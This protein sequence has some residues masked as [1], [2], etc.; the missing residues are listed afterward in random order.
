MIDFQNIATRAWHD[1]YVD[2][3]VPPHEIHVT[4][5]DTCARRTW[6]Q[7]HNVPVSDI[8]S[9]SSSV[10]PAVMGTAVHRVYVP[11]FA[12]RL[13]SHPDIAR[14]DAHADVTITVDGVTIHGEADIVAI[15]T[16]N[17]GHIWDLK[18]VYTPR[19]YADIVS[20]G[21]PDNHVRQVVTYAYM[22][23]QRTGQVCDSI[24]LYYVNASRSGDGGHNTGTIPFTDAH[25]S[26]ASD[27]IKS[28][29]QAATSTLAP[30]QWFADKEKISSRS[31][32]SEDRVRVCRSCPWQTTCLGRPVTGDSA[33]QPHQDVAAQLITA[34]QHLR[35]LEQ[36]QLDKMR[37]L[38]GYSHNKK[39]Y[40]S[41]SKILSDF[42]NDI[43]VSDGMYDN[44]IGGAYI[45]STKTRKIM[46]TSAVK[47]ILTDNNIDI[48][49]KE[50]SPSTYIRE[51][52]DAS[53]IKERTSRESS[54]NDENTSA[55]TTDDVQ[56]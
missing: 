6:Y 46:D 40:N 34:R 53:R 24:S 47:N 4:S 21:A 11:G 25:R 33:G 31:T 29:V 30:P 23:E 13:Q 51:V 28:C 17:R 45:V 8:A 19:R 15:D 22:W 54:K 9:S 49:M 26:I 38:S 52:K 10:V 35:T 37:E 5:M 27:R 36:G 50:T 20:S 3:Q 14:A 41:E 48:P 7:H 43:G 56:I 2:S 39:H 12:E 55:V 18:T 32:S 1:L 16:G 42:L 44:G